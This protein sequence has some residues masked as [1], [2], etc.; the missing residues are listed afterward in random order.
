MAIA[1]YV[2]Q[3][4]IPAS[5]AKPTS[6][7]SGGTY[8]NYRIPASS[9]NTTR[10]VAGN[11]VYAATP[12]APQ[13]PGSSS[14]SGGGG[15]PGAGASVSDL[16]NYALRSGLDVNRLPGI[17]DARRREQEANQKRIA[18]AVAVFDQ[19]SQNLKDRIPGLE[20]M[21]DIR[22]QG[23][24][25]GLQQFIDTAN[26]EQGKRVSEIQE[27]RGR[28]GE[29]FTK[30]ERG[31]R[32]AAKS[33]SQNLRKLFGG[34][35]VLDS[36]AYRDAN[37]ESSRD[38]LQQLGDLKRDKASRIA[39]SEREE[40]DIKNY[41]SES[42]NQQ[43]QNITLQKDNVRAQ[44]DQ[45][46]K[47]ILGDIQLNDRQ[48]IEAIE[49]ANE[50]LAQRMTDLDVQ[51]QRLS[52]EARQFDMNF[53][54]EQKKLSQKGSSAGYKDALN[55]SKAIQNATTNAQKILESYGMPVTTANVS[56]LLKQQG[57][58]TP[59]EDQFGGSYVTSGMGND[60][61]Q[62]WLSGAGGSSW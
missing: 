60:P 50:R 56:Q 19:M 3:K 55:Y 11:T 18:A 57:F 33:I 38:I 52:E 23:L 32:T 8:A 34:A 21:R 46:I 43:Q 31:V 54:L 4:V 25:T 40:Q 37:I 48:K 7:Y 1:S 36:T 22:L 17:E 47:G 15:A 24:D 14:N 6:S 42:I 58:T 53:A 39:T 61:L 35:G 10:N 45:E 30:G 59:E 51:A 44:T 5:S 27:S 12:Q 26:R 29:E 49:S 2:N 28:I 16:E 13:G 62:S 20:Q 9:E 41:Y